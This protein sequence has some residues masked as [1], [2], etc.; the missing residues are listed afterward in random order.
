MHYS[1]TMNSCIYTK[2][3]LIV[4]IKAIDTKLDDPISAS[5][6][7]TNQGRQSFAKQIN[8]MRNQRNWY[9]KMLQQFYPDNYDDMLVLGTSRRGCNE[10]Y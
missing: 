9:Y 2:A 3:E 7:D 4:K 8:E 6:L 5:L 10:F 1:N